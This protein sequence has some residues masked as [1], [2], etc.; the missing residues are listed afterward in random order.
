MEEGCA[1]NATLLFVDVCALTCS[2]G[3]A[4]S[5][6]SLTGLGFVKE[7]AGS[8]SWALPEA[9]PEPPLGGRWM[10]GSQ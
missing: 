5:F 7:E 9:V 2:F 1:T 4:A 6:E 8:K 3:S 10:E